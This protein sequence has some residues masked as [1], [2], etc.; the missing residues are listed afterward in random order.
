MNKKAK[1]RLSGLRWGPSS[2]AKN[3]LIHQFLELHGGVYLNLTSVI[4]RRK[5]KPL[6]LLLQKT[7]HGTRSSIIKRPQH[8]QTPRQTGRWA[9]GQAGASAFAL[10]TPEKWRIQ[11]QD[12][13]KPMLSQASRVCGPCHCH[14][15]S[16]ALTGVLGGVEVGFWPLGSSSSSSSGCGSSSG[17]ERQAIERVRKRLGRLSSLGSDSD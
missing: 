4:G 14:L 9:G 8:E 13:R 5:T 15:P 3:T 1:G 2:V 10:K 12:W 16:S 6:G 7:Q 11:P 17:S